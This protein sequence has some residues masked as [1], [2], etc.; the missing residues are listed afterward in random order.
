[1]PPRAYGLCAMIAVAELLLSCDGQLWGRANDE[2]TASSG[3]G[4][5]PE[6]P[7]AG[8]GERGGAGIYI[9]DTGFGGDYSSPQYLENFKKR[10]RDIL[11]TSYVDG[12]TLDYSWRSFAPIGEEESGLY[13]HYRY[14]PIDYALEI[15]NRGGKKIA[16]TIH[17]A[18]YS[19]AYVKEICP[20]FAYVHPHPAVGQRRVPIPWTACYY[21]YLNRMVTA[22]SRRY[23]GHP[24]IRFVTINGPSTLVGVETNWPMKRGSISSEDLVVLGFSLAKYEAHWIRNIEY[25]SKAFPNTPL[26][27]GL[28]NR[29]DMD[30]LDPMAV[31]ST[32]ERIRDHAI[33]YYSSSTMRMDKRIILRLLG[34]SH[35]HRD[36]F[37]GPNNGITSSSYI[38]L[39]W[40]QR[41]QARIM[42]EMIGVFS[43][44]TPPVTPEFFAQVLANGQSWAGEEIDVKY[45]DLLYY[46]DTIR[47]FVTG[48]MF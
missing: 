15:A 19:P 47:E 14:E 34:L 1:M 21:K 29:I 40:T 26:A 17:V 39:V 10:V 5:L 7:P 23:N 36:F 2:A 33:T 12:I 42:Y 46:G 8:L 6:E 27:L 13:Q 18:E 25:Y 9:Q 48:E 45:P 11:S 38:D 32:V 22:L 3:T 44:R 16:I 41:Q 35:D 37:P 31:Y 24:S 28:H 43:K 20:T 30:G 4:S